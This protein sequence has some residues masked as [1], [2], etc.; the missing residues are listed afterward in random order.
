MVPTAEI[1]FHS[2]LRRWCKSG[3]TLLSV[4][5][6]SLPESSLSLFFYIVNRLDAFTWMQCAFELHPRN[7]FGPFLLLRV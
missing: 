5:H 6:V 3:K 7:R 1:G 4:G 2:R